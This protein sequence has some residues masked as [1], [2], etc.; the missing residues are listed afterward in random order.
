[1]DCKRHNRTETGYFRTLWCN[2]CGAL[3][4]WSDSG[5]IYWIKS[6]SQKK[7]RKKKKPEPEAR[8]REP[9]WVIDRMMDGVR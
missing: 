8:P 6:S 2:K 5:R 1:M 7:K 4:R 9:Q 3:G